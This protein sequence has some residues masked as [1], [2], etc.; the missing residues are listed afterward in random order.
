MWVK[1]NLGL[2]TKL[3][4]NAAFNAISFFSSDF[5]HK[6]PGWHVNKLQEE[7]L[8]FLKLPAIARN[9]DKTFQNV[10]KLSLEHEP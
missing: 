10:R 3:Q 5:L 4:K 2:G 8:E 6:S 1:Y 9:L 7:F